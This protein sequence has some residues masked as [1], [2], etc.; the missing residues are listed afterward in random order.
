MGSTAHS[1]QCSTDV[2]AIL[3]VAEK[4]FQ[5]KINRKWVPLSGG[6]SE[7]ASLLPWYKNGGGDPMGMESFDL[8]WGVAD[9]PPHRK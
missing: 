4:L 7:K 5:S 3:R 1:C 2:H 8:E 9:T 6:V